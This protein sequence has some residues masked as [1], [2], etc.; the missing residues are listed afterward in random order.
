MSAKQIK[1]ITP[2]GELAV[3]VPVGPNTTAA[4]ILDAAGLSSAFFL[5]AP[6]GQR[7]SQPSDKVEPLVEDGAT[8]YANPWAEV[9]TDPLTALAI[10][11]AA[12]LTTVL[13]ILVAAALSSATKRTS[14]ST[15]G[16]SSIQVNRPQPYWC[17][18]GWRQSGAEYVGIYDVGLQHFD[19]KIT[20]RSAWD[21]RF[22]VLAPPS[23]IA[24]CGEHRRCFLP[25][26]SQGASGHRW[27]EVHFKQRP[28]D[29]SAG[30]LAIQQ[31]L[32]WG[33]HNLWGDAA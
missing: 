14:R 9:G 25:R 13:L 12:I 17:Q 32:R 7:F 2:G 8:L 26:K 31:M 19:G 5:S 29:V 27:Y 22:E 24:A 6:D 10:I 23:L 21:C 3:F 1:V 28:Q 4:E 30:I 16:S 20:F 15:V 11:A 33:A 18:A